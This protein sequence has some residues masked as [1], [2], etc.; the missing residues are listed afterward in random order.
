MLPVR[1]YQDV[2]E[3]SPC[4]DPARRG[5]CTPEWRGTAL[6]VLRHPEVSVGDKLWVVLRRAWIPA[7]VLHTFAV[8]C[9][10]EALRYL[11]SDDPAFRLALEAKQRWLAQT[12]SLDEVFCA[13]ASADEAA[14]IVRSD[15]EA[16]NGDLFAHPTLWAAYAIVAAVS[17][18]SSVA[19]RFSAT[20]LA[21]AVACRAT[22]FDSH[23]NAYEQAYRTKRQREIRALIK[24]IEQYEQAPQEYPDSEQ[25]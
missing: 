17:G 19:A 5:F 6:D 22:L 20:N 24:L 1:T 13:H 7:W 10:S 21:T 11:E 8:Q 23:P 12:G 4:Y 2:M 14:R 18:N 15:C 16:K 3:L 9:G 25:F